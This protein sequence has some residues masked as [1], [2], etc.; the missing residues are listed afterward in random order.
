LRR[1]SPALCLLPTITTAQWGSYYT[2]KTIQLIT[3]EPDAACARRCQMDTQ[4]FKGTSK[5][6]LPTSLSPFYASSP[7][8]PGQVSETGP[9]FRHKTDQ[10][11][12]IQ[13]D[14]YRLDPGRMEEGD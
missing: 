1:K 8:K 7:N 9:T 11:K 5:E 14:G 4:Q 2:N 13:G 6:H 3:E 12:A 10:G